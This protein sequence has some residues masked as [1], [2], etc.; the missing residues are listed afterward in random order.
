[1]TSEMG[2]Q[3]RRSL[4]DSKGEQGLGPGP[5]PCRP[6]PERHSEDTHS[7]QRIAKLS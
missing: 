5:P 4:C 3:G 1:M 6:E 7:V 2:G